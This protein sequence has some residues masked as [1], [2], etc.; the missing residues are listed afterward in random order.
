LLALFS[1]VAPFS[2]VSIFLY[3]P[4]ALQEM[5]FAVWLIV[6]GFDA[7]AIDALATEIAG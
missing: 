7:T 1:L 4:I 3:V 6:K 5:V 2:T